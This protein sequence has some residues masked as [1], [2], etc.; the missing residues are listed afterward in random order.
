MELVK[1][2]GCVLEQLYYK[3]QEDR[4]F[5]EEAVKQCGYFDPSFGMEGLL[6]MRMQS[7]Y[8]DLY[9]P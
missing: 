3:F 9:L 5:Q 1:E 4:K 8:P 7:C 2:K 6:D